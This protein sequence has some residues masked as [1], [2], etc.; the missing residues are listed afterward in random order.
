[1]NRI[2][3]NSLGGRASRLREG[4]TFKSPPRAMVNFKVV[5]VV[6]CVLACSSIIWQAWHAAPI[7]R[8]YHCGYDG[9]SWCRMAVGKRG[10]DPYQRRFLLPLLVGFTRPTLAN[11]WIRFLVLDVLS[12]LGLLACIGVFTKRLARRFGAS[13]QASRLG[14]VM[15]VSL[16]SL[17]FYPWHYSFMVPVN[18]DIAATALGTAWLLTLTSKDGPVLWASVPLAFLTQACRDMC[19]P[20]M[21][22]G[23][24][25][26]FVV[27]KSRRRLAV[28]NGAAVLVAVIVSLTEPAAQSGF[29]SWRSVVEGQLR[30]NFG[31]LHGFV[32]YL[33]LV[34]LG[35]GFVSL[36]ALPTLRL[37]RRDPTVAVLWSYVVIQAVVATTTGGTT[38]RYLFPVFA[39]LVPLGV[40]WVASRPTVPSQFALIVAAAASIGLWRPW[41]VLS[42]NV[43]GIL[44]FF[45][46]FVEPWSVNRPHL[47]SDLKLVAV[48]ALGGAAVGGLLW[49]STNGASR[50]APALARQR[51]AADSGRENP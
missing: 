31:S 36:L 27:V 43:P 11:A 40:G 7:L 32:I 34:T 42:G 21:L 20:P 6:V 44:R 3:Q 39:V 30:D 38:D 19:G 17:P 12:A 4:E 50:I 45:D 15:A 48:G 35:V 46:Q 14:A 22:A 5:T 28:A 18:T 29:P 49:L 9:D 1:M 25:V 47:V 23:L 16:V 10:Y 37:V 13:A 41:F 24:L 26:L 51:N 2:I 33:W 8:N